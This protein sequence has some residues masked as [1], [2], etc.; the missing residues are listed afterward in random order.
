MC[1]KGTYDKEGVPG[2]GVSPSTVSPPKIPLRQ[3]FS[4]LRRRRQSGRILVDYGLGVCTILCTAL[5]F[6]GCTVAPDGTHPEAEAYAAIA[7]GLGLMV[8]L[9]CV[10][11]TQLA[12]PR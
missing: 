2:V 1:N 4:Y 12:R 7:F 8:F 10:A 5:L 6:T 11:V 9:F 3:R